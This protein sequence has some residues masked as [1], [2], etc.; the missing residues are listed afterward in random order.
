L[1]GL[2][3]NI[4]H[5]EG[6]HRVHWKTGISVPTFVIS[7]F[8]MNV[9]IPVADH[10]QAFRIVMIPALLSVFFYVLP[11]IQKAVTG[12]KRRPSH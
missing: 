11:E 4:K 12:Q 6:S 7:A 1:D 9:K 2:K 3:M 8:F 5:R 10:L